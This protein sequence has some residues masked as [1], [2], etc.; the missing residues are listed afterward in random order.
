LAAGGLAEIAGDG[1]EALVGGDGEGLATCHGLVG[2]RAV[3]AVMDGNA[4]A[5]SGEGFGDTTAETATGTGDENDG[6]GI[7]GKDYSGV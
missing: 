5:E 4:D 3:G 7:H 6:L 2:C 1:N